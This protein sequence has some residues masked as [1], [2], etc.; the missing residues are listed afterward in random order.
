MA[1]NKKMVAYRYWD[2]KKQPVY[3]ENP[4]FP[5][6]VYSIPG[7]EALYAVTSY[8][9]KDLEAKVNI[10]PEILGFKKYRVIDIDNDQQVPV[11]KNT[12]RLNIKKHDLKVFKILPE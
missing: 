2:E 10:I 6:I 7:K 8:A 3:S 12:F 4:D 1:K 9:D 5:G 11:E